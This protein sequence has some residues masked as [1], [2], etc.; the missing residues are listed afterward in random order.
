MEDAIKDGVDVK[1]YFAWSLLDNFE[2]SAGYAVR[3]GMT[4]VDYTTQQRYIKDSGN[5]YSEWVK[6]HTFTTQTQEEQELLFLQA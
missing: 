1:G 4:Y 2:W 6:S 3:F 5:W